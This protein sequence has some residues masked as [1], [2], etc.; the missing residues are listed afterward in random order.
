MHKVNKQSDISLTE[1]LFKAYYELQSRNIVFTCTSYRKLRE[2]PEYQE[3]PSY[4]TYIKRYGSW[5]DALSKTGL[6]NIMVKPKR[7]GAVEKLYDIEVDGVLEKG[8]KCRVCMN[9]KQLDNMV[10]NKFR[11]SGKDTICKECFAERGRKYYSNNRDKCLD[12]AK[13]WTKNNSEQIKKQKAKWYEENKEEFT[14]YRKAYYEENKEK[15]FERMRYH[16]KKWRTNQYSLPFIL[17][18]EEEQEIID[19]Y[20]NSCSLTRMKENAAMEH[21]IPLSWGHGGTYKG[22]LY[23]LNGTLN[24][25]KKNKNPFKWI[26]TN[27]YQDIIDMSEWDKLI[28]RLA[29]ENNMTVAEFREFVYWCEANKR[30]EKER[31]SD[32]RLSA[33]IWRESLVSQG[34][35]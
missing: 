34:G 22:N 31:K 10:S 16:T 24:L 11:K 21:F 26:E 14:A 18:I 25:S 13:K 7:K 2:E 20:Q 9:V 3:L 28:Q 1:S 32:T 27:N 23:L 8:K 5:K 15:E 29:T 19:L 6:S 12:A 33:G 30:T 35:Y 17:T 4:Y